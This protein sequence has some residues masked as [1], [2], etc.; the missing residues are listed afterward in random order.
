MGNVL[1]LPN[2]TEI[3]AANIVVTYADKAQK[4][5]SKCSINGPGVIFRNNKVIHFK[6]GELD[7][8]TL[9]FTGAIQ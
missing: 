7:P 2:N 9:Q 4:I 1:L 6:Y 5:I 3:F 8:N